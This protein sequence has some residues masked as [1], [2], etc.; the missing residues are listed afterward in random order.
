MRIV[1]WTIP[2]L[3]S[4]G[5]LIDAYQQTYT[6]YYMVPCPGVYFC[7]PKVSQSN[8]S[9]YLVYIP[10]LVYLS[11]TV[12][13]LLL[14]FTKMLLTNH[15][16]FYFQWRTLMFGVQCIILLVF[17]EVFFFYFTYSRW[18]FMGTV[19]AY[20]ICVAS[21]PLDPSPPCAEQHLDSY[22]YF[23][24]FTVQLMG[25]MAVFCLYVYWSNASVWRWWC[26]VITQR[27]VMRSLVSVSTS[28]G[29][30]NDA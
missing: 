25:W 6:Q 7:F 23:C 8:S 17:L 14:A 28:A 27:E 10:S 9:L 13:C 3:L 19:A 16:F 20:P 29:N 30:S 24:L 18:D 21:H 11:V 22:W 26:H 15:Q 12:V 4:I 5:V 1:S 2:F